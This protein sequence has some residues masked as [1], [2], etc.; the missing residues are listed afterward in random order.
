MYSFLGKSIWNYV[1]KEEKRIVLDSNKTSNHREVLYEKA[2]LSLM[3]ETSKNI[4]EKVPFLAKLGLDA[5]K[6]TKNEL[7]CRYF[8]IILLRFKVFAFRV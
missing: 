7:L 4:Y 1:F 8:Q 5:Y 2:L 3:S 6:V